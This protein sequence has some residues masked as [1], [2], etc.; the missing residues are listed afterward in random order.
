MFGC[1][2]KMQVYLPDGLYERVKAEGAR[3]NVSGVL[4]EALGER[5]AELE[6]HDALTEAL[7]AHAGESGPFAPDEL[8]R[9]AEADAAAAVYPAAKKRRSSAA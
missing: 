3:L 4:Q 5:L 7:A 1:V 2:P 9:Q 6:R 8:D